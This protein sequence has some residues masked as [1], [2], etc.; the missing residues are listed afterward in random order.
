LGTN[1]AQQTPAQTHA[2]GQLVREEDDVDASEQQFHLGCRQLAD[3]FREQLFVERHNLRNIRHGV[4]RQAS[5]T[6][7]EA[8]V[9]GRSGPHEI[10]R[11]R[12]AHHANS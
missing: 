2:L 11:E 3:A 7:T 10:A 1:D 12:H 5:R 4:L 8:H 9:S 6:S